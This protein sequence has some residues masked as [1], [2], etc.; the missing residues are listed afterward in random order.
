MTNYFVHDSATVDDGAIIG[1]GSKVWHYSHIMGTA[2][3]GE[4]CSLGQN[5]FIADHVR[6][7]NG[8]KIQNNVSLYEGVILE[9]DVF[10][11]PSCVFTNVY[12]PR[13][14]VP[15]KDQYLKTHIK[16]GVSIGANATIICGN[17]IGEFAFIGAGTVVTKD[18]PPFALVYG[19]PSRVM[20]WVCYCGEKLKFINDESASCSDCTRE[21]SKS[22]NQVKMIMPQ[23]EGNDSDE[24]ST[25]RPAKSV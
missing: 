3:I 9:D 25:T 13:S 5:V 20:G 10:C 17:T 8:V 24:S 15:K 16:H 19:N 11:G 21:Y 1:A 22:G 2:Q 4:D 7:G 18:I 6:V 14:A 12:N 23:S